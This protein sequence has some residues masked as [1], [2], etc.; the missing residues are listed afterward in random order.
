[1]VRKLKS[2]RYGGGGV[3][4]VMHAP[5]LA[6]S[7]EFLDTPGAVYTVAEN[8]MAAVQKAGWLKLLASTRK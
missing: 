2:G 4:G 8:G 7:S 6:T 3:Q 1:M 5:L